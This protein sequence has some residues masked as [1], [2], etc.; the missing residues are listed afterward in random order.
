MRPGLSGFALLAAFV[1][2]E[3][4]AD[5]Q[6]NCA[7]FR[8]GGAIRVYAQRVAP[9]GATDPGWVPDASHVCVAPGHEVAFSAAPAG[10]SAVVVAWT[11]LGRDGSDIRAQRLEAGGGVTAGWPATGIS[12]SSATGDQ[13]TPS[14]ADDGAGGAFIV[15]QDFRSGRPRI[16]AQRVSGAG[17][18]VSGW[19]QDGLG[20]GAGSRDQVAPVVANDGAGGALVAWQ[21]FENGLFRVRL[22]RLTGAGVVSPGWPAAG[23]I[24][25]PSLRHQV[26]PV[27]VSDDA[28]GAL[29]VWEESELGQRKLRA[30]RVNALAALEPGWPAAGLVLATA[31]GQQRSA[32]MIRDGAGGA[33]VAWQDS[34]SG[35]G[36]IYAQRITSAGVIAS[37]WA[38]TGVAGCSQAAEQSAPAILNDGAGGAYLAWEDFRGGSTDVYAQRV[39]GAG[40]LSAGWPTDGVAMSIATGEQYAPRLMPD[41]AGGAIATWFDT[42][43]FPLVDVPPSGGDEPVFALFGLRPSPAIGPVQV[44]FALPSGG[45]ARLELLDVA[46]RRILRREV[47]SL[48]TGRHVVDL[49]G[50]TALPAGIYFIRLTH[51]GRSL[52]TTACVLR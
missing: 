3:A 48:G 30:A 37:G 20:L 34:R 31:S 40:A 51:A 12:V 2:S 29:V 13:N 24:P 10:S 35:A 36:D 15:W 42:R 49:R 44:A 21:E 1:A 6:T 39:T 52:T 14:A 50:R 32:T 33:L 16:F 19:P 38:A 43:R 5:P 9:D 41:G 45:P 26:S 7:D 25:C 8:I 47:G 18:I 17:A 4:M 46:G 23:V 22:V 27:L 28:G 11:E